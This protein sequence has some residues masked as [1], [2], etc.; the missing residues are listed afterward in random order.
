MLIG[1]PPSVVPRISVDACRAHKRLVHRSSVWSESSSWI[2]RNTFVCDS[3]DD[4][5]VHVHSF[6]SVNRILPT[7]LRHRKN[8]I[9]SRPQHISIFSTSKLVTIV[10][11]DLCCW[12]SIILEG[13]QCGS[14]RAFLQLIHDRCF[15]GAYSNDCQ[16][17]FSRINYALNYSWHRL[18]WTMRNYEKSP[19]FSIVDL[20]QS[21]YFLRPSSPDRASIGVKYPAHAVMN[22]NANCKRPYS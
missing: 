22:T 20:E 13:I 12:R 5:M 21:Q 6:R 1:P 2:V 3:H 19:H 11:R 15:R 18:G 16:K 4:V 10:I 7:S 17:P 8:L 9:M 14:A